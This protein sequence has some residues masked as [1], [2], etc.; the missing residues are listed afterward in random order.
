[1]A[2]RG[3]WFSRA[4]NIS[5]GSDIF[6]PLTRPYLPG[7]GLDNTHAPVPNGGVG[8]YVGLFGPGIPPRCGPD[9]LYCLGLSPVFPP[10]VSL[11]RLRIMSGCSEL[12]E[13]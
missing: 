11:P 6:L 12:V 10:E 8:G 3:P 1:M 4:G 9:L 2:V 13:F 7:W 5:I